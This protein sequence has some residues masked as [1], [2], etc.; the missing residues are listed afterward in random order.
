MDMQPLSAASTADLRAMAGEALAQFPSLVIAG[1]DGAEQRAIEVLAESAAQEH[2]DTELARA[3][4]A[5]AGAMT[6]PAA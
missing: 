3:L 4:V 2:V 6:E 5:Y 1:A